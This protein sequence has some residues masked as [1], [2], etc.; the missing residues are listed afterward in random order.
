MALMEQWKDVVGYEGY[1]QVSN[2]GRVRSVDRVVRHGT[3]QGV[4]KLKGRLLRPGVSTSGHLLVVL[5]KHGIEHT[6]K[7]HK[8]VA[9]TWLDSRPQGYVIRHGVNGVLDNSILN[10]CYGTRI[11]DGRDRRRDKTHCGQPVKRSDGT[12][13]INMRVA[14]ELSHCCY[15]NIWKV[16]NG[17]RNTAGGY[18]WE[19]VER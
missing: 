11:E 15:S 9:L 16:C 2:L 8:L 14:A 18:G 3:G 6:F 1:Y 19:Y 10:L 12:E 4:R 7:V 5:C 13:F 17:K